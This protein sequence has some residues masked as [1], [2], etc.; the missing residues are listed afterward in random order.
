MNLGLSLSLRSGGG[1]A[2]AAAVNPLFAIYEGP[3]LNGL[4][5]TLTTNVAVP[6]A[7]VTGATTLYLTPFISGYLA[8]YVSSVWTAY[9]TAQVSIALGT[10]TSGRNYDVFAYYTGSA[11]AL[12]LST[13]WTN[14]TTRATALATQDG[15]Y[16]KT[17]DATRRYVGTI[18]TTSTTATE[19]SAA[20]RFV[21]NGPEPWRQSTRPLVSPAEPADSWSYALTTIR[22]ANANAANQVE[23]VVGLP[24]P[25]RADLTA[26]GALN[27]TSPIVGIGVDSTSAFVAGQRNTSTVGAFSQVSAVYSGVLSAGYHYVA[28]LERANAAS[29]AVFYGD[30]GL[31]N[32]QAGLT[33][34]VPG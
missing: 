1:G 18:R 2:A 8:L 21:Y 19:D 6:T 13:A 22:Q 28:W 30:A 11:V 27:A 3:M 4:R 17:G 10:L 16:V 23:V 25:V 7:D 34:Q 5:L 20:K 29:S 26:M 12:E 9:S 14:D 15:I 32:V 24:T 31:P 33:A